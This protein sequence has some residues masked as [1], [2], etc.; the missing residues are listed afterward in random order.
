MQD[1]EYFLRLL[2]GHL[3]NTLSPGEKDDFLNAISSGAY[4]E[5]LGEEI[6]ATIN[7]PMGAGQTLS[8]QKKE[9]I[10]RNIL[11]VETPVIPLRR[12]FVGIAAAI[13]LLAVTTIFL[14]QNI[15]KTQDSTA[16]NNMLTAQNNQS[17]PMSIQ[18]EDGT[19][20]ELQPGSKL[21]Y[22]EK[23]TDPGR[24][25]TLEGTA[26]F[27]IATDPRRPFNVLSGDLVT[28]VLGTS[29]TIDWN[30]NRSV[31]KVM[32][33]SGKVEVSPQHAPAKGA[34]L[35]PNQQ[36][37]YTKDSTMLTPALVD[38]PQV[39]EGETA[40]FTFKATPVSGIFTLLQKSYGI[41]IVM[42]DKNIGKSLFT[43]DLSHQSFY[44]ALKIICLSL[45][46]SYVIRGT[47]VFITH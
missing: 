43:G 21:S 24:Q 7:T 14:Y 27:K 41:D 22:P 30:K 23:F 34:I 2:K 39:V 28:K 17:G 10:I 26:F 46:H 37:T 42:E 12:R 44:T 4:K 9:Q 5:V 16:A 36:I 11:A 35:T 13:L 18:L 33:R 19:I 3:E 29:F 1:P 31:M 45:N 25:V 32:V 47:K 40:S 38:N 20:I 15:H 8:A 6:L